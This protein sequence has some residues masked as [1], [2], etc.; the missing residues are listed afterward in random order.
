[1]S[2]QRVGAMI[3][4]AGQTV[5]IRRVTGTTS[6]TF[7]DVAAK[8]SVR[9][10]QPE[11]LMGPIQQGD[12]QVIVGVSEMILAVWPAPPRRNDK[13]IIDGVTTNVEAVEARH[14]REDIAF[15]VMRCRG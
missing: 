10:Y 9:G 2:V 5:T 7:T 12:R 14:F 15:F 11:E 6:Q 4:R 13:V 1:V 8:A 3:A